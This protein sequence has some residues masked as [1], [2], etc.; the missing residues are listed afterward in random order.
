MKTKLMMAGTVLACLAMTACGGGK[1]RQ[2]GQDAGN[3]S[4]EVEVQASEMT[5]P[6]GDGVVNGKMTLK[7][8]L[9]I[10]NTSL[11][12]MSNIKKICGNGFIV[13]S[14][15]YMPYI[16]D[17]KGKVLYAGF[18]GTKLEPVTDNWYPR[19]VPEADKFFDGQHI[20]RCFPDSATVITPVFDAEVD[21]TTSIGLTALKDDNILVAM[22]EYGE[23]MAIYNPD[24]QRISDWH[25]YIVQV[26]AGKYLFE[27]EDGM[28][29]CDE[30]GTPIVDKVITRSDYS[31]GG[32]LPYKGENKL[33]G[34]V[35]V[36]GQILTEPVYEYMQ[37]S[38]HLP[39]VK[40]D[41]VHGYLDYDM[42][43][44]PMDEY[45]EIN[46]FK[47]GFATVKKDGKWGYI[48][49]ELKLV[50]P[51]VY[52]KTETFRKGVAKVTDGD[53]SILVNTEGKVLASI[54]RQFN[55][56]K[57]RFN[58]DFNILAWSY[59]DSDRDSEYLYSGKGLEMSAKNF[60]FARING[61]DTV[62]AYKFKD[63]KYLVRVRG[64][65]L[66]GEFDDV[67]YIP[68]KPLVLVKRYGKDLF[69]SYDGETGYDG[70]EELDKVIQSSW[71]TTFDKNTV[72]QNIKDNFMGIKGVTDVYIF[73]DTYKFIGENRVYVEVAIDNT[74]SSRTGV[75][76]AEVS[77]SPDGSVYGRKITFSWWMDAYSKTSS[78]VEFGVEEDVV[79][80]LQGNTFV[81]ASGMKVNFVGSCMYMNGARVTGPLRVILQPGIYSTAK[82]VGSN[83]TLTVNGATGEIIN[84]ADG[85]V[86]RKE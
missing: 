10:I 22:G 9:R 83:A 54:D 82:L 13:T 84:N 23:Q 85:N 58:V 19:F 39:K 55:T 43:F 69:M 21:D 25:S 15:G 63:T 72:M 3:G 47:E 29:L 11:M 20:V 62:Y 78:G 75:Y 71:S 59:P 74:G 61:T 34:L 66:E 16:H 36:N 50:V 52:T 24:G 17:M 41:G 86:Y 49:D 32:C 8:S 45:E 33:V 28:Y 5:A 2:N 27:K 7:D 26:I 65:K 53:E 14:D 12:Q 81:G 77:L 79:A 68:G 42:K 76:D 56:W 67:E 48:N 6:D 80:F 1:S 46:E 18:Y 4:P 40:K 70:W 37:T 30:K 57:G 31:G 73:K 44:V 51:C 60:K 35:S 38:K 64:Q